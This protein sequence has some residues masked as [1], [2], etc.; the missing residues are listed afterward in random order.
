MDKKYLTDILMKKNNSFFRKT[1]DVTS[2]CYIHDQQINTA[3][4][5]VLQLGCNELRS[6]H[7]NLVSPMQAGKTSVCNAVVN[8]ILKSRLYKSMMV[9]KFI[10]ISGMNDCGLKNQTHTR[11][12]EQVIGANK[13]NVY[14][15]KKSKKNLSENKFFI[16]KNSDL[17]K[18]D[19]NIDNSVIFVDES[20]YGSNENNILT[21]FLIKHGIDWKNKN[22]L[23]SRNIYIVSVSAT[24]FDE[25]IS[26]E[27]NSKKAVEI[28]IDKNYVGVNDY[29][30]NDLI[31]DAEKDDII[32]DGAIFD[33]I[34]DADQRMAENNELGVVII[35]TRNFDIIKENAYVQ[36][37]FDVF[38]MFSSGTKIEYD[39][40]NSM[41][42][43][44]HEENLR[45]N[46]YKLLD[47]KPNHKPLIV[48]IKGAFRAGITIDSAYKD[49]IYMVYDYSLKA[50]AT[51]Q[52][53]LGRMC[54]YRKDKEKILNTYFYI[55]KKFADMYGAWSNDFSNKSLIPCDKTKYEWIDNGYQGNDV[56][57]GSK[58]CG[59]F[60]VKLSDDDIIKLYSTSKSRR[61]QTASA[62]PIVKDI[63]MKNNFHIEY[64]YIG[65][66]CLK[67]KNNYAKSSQEK[68]FNLF[69]EDSLVYQFR[70][71]K[72]KSFIKDT[73]RDFL[74]KDDLG[75]K[76][77]SVVLD[78]TI[79][80]DGDNIT[81][82]GN[83][84]LL[85]YY[86]EVGQK[87]MTF[88]RK[89]QYKPHKDTRI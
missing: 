11:I 1:D 27:I 20:H 2:N 75:K 76:C 81:I 24:P 88:N 9:K 17:L 15:G 80:K 42:K 25:L 30:S 51:A 36:A 19:G 67:G 65:E 7:I 60:I 73:N 35:R 38:E 77:I 59:N 61:T 57:F 55:N 47:I 16:L 71:E 18:Y 82:D 34:I 39:K 14:F 66:T 62:E 78:A 58:S 6:N 79:T 37:N 64:D 26:D 49:M 4:R 72:I 70:P 83:K 69:S 56:I 3:R 89:S 31:K 22:E 33:Y 32:E 53:L 74:T 41:F 40:L 44:L 5:I 43:E 23:I 52:A 12:L 8:V 29:L 54:G 63:L 46:N 50:D 48:L 13:Y 45:M 85:V 21:K 84:Q 86:V 68:R 28:E 87:R 10:F